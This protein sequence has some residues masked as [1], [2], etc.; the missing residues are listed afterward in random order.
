MGLPPHQRHS[1]RKKESHSVTQA[2]VQWH[3]LSSLQPLPPNLL[4]QPPEYLG[5]QV[6]TTTPVEMGFHHVSHAGLE[7]MTS[8]NLPA[9]ASQSAGIT[10]VSHRAQLHAGNL[11]MESCSVAQAGVQVH[12]LGSLQPPSPGFKRFFCLNLLSSWD[13][14]H[15]PPPPANFYIFSKDGVLPYWPGWSQTSD[16]MIRL[17]W[18]PKV[19][20]DQLGSPQLRSSPPS[21]GDKLLKNESQP[22]EISAKMYKASEGLQ[23]RVMAIGVDFGIRKAETNKETGECGFEKSGSKVLWATSNHDLHRRPAASEASWLTWPTRQAGPRKGSQLSCSRPVLHKG[24]HTHSTAPMVSRS[25]TQ[26]GV[27]W[28]NLSSLQTPPPRFKQFSY[29]S[30]LSNCNYRCTPPHLANF[31]YLG[32]HQVG[33]AGLELLTS[34]DPP[35]SASQSAGITG[36]NHRTWPN[37]LIYIVLLLLLRLECNGVISAH[38]NLCFQGS[39]YSPASASRVAGITDMHHQTQLILYFLVKTGFLHVAP[40]LPSELCLR[41]DLILLFFETESCTVTQAIAQW[42]DLSSLQFQPPGFKQFSCLS[43]LSSWDYRRA[44][45]YPANFFVFLV[46]MGFHHVGPDGLD[47]LT[48]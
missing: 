5:L 3:N 27:Q 44:P 46:E 29:L 40:F 31:L 15:E 32:L 22:K 43:L 20:M 39:C 18:P 45:P 4:P 8:G 6:C 34:S 42:R 48:S 1:I 35:V 14:K 24:C 25:L 23:Y 13:Y 17:P 30:L 37:I 11:D 19:E 9:S 38:L 21:W 16:L 7:L 41:V 47:L 36:M 33:Q 26:A 10:G 12:D 28:C 2:R